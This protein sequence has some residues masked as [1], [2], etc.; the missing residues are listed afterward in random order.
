MLESAFPT[1]VTYLWKETFCLILATFTEALP[2]DST[3]GAAFIGLVA[4]AV[5][6]GVTLLQ[7]FLYY[8][9][10]H[11]DSWLTKTIVFT[12]WV[13]DTAHLCL[14]TI[15]LYSYLVTNYN[16][17]SALTRSTWAMNLQTDCNGLIGLIV[18]CFFARRVWKLS[19]NFL[20]TA[21]IVIFSCIHFSLGVFFTVQGFVLV[22]TSRFAKLIWVTSAGMGSA[23]AADVTI[24]VSLCYYLMQNRTGFKRPFVR[25]DSLIS[26]LMIYSLTTGLV[27]SFIA[28]II[29]VTVW[30][31]APQTCPEMTKTSSLSNLQFAVMPDKYV[32]LG[33]FWLIG[34]CYVNSILA[35]LNSRDS[36]R[37]R[38]TPQADGTFFQLTPFRVAT[39]NNTVSKTDYGS[40]IS[41]PP[42]AAKF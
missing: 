33:F 25:T 5:L 37:E 30:C 35:A 42:S 20:L 28:F 41:P 7:T 17:P 31:I 26:T 34:K 10:Y 3:Y 38:A 39:D 18:Q 40:I 23:A 1:S 12:L 16:N 36:L 6:Y 32:W 19:R 9:N 2:L 29:V 4:S 21:A 14:C 8:K 27:T 24:A 15:A 22:D 13:L 11:T